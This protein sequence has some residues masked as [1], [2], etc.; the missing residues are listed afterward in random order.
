MYVLTCA[1][2]SDLVEF[3]LDLIVE[4]TVKPP[5]NV[6]SAELSLGN[7]AFYMVYRYNCLGI[8]FTG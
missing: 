6:N 3:S 2:I 4:L 7:P 5:S 8:F 1:I